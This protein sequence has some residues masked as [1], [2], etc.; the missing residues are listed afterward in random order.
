[1]SQTPTTVS[2]LGHT[3]SL[4]KEIFQDLEMDK[5]LLSMILFFLKKKNIWMPPNIWACPAEKSLKPKLLFLCHYF[6]K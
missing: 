6:Q 1:M 5:K 2:P 3:I 4:W